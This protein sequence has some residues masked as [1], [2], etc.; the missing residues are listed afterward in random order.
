[1]VKCLLMRRINTGSE[2]SSVWHASTVVLCKI[3]ASHESRYR[4]MIDG[5]SQHE[6]TRWKV[7]LTVS[8]N[9]HRTRWLLNVSIPT[10]HGLSTGR[11][12]FISSVKDIV[13]SFYSANDDWVDVCDMNQDDMRSS[14]MMD[15]DQAWS[16]GVRG[17]KSTGCCATNR[18]MT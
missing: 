8:A 1:M 9:N 7:K 17:T 15:A 12:R 11:T 18:L 13:C 10:K 2:L 3:C 4:M 14:P 16:I 6:D 5:F